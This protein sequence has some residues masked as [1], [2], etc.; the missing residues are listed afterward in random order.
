MTE[1]LAENDIADLK[2]QDTFGS[3]IEV[4]VLRIHKGGNVIVFDGERELEVGARHLHK[5]VKRETK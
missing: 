2:L 3:T 5:K 4:K 1:T